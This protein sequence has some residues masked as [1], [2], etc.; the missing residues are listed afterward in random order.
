MKVIVDWALQG[1]AELDA[2]S[3]SD[4]ENFIQVELEK[5]IKNNNDLLNSIGASS[6][7]GTGRKPDE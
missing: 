5:L 4:A 6:V 1:S 2:D 7:Q 3:I